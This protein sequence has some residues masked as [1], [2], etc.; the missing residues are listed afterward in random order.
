M[1]LHGPGTPGMRRTR[2]PTGSTGGVPPPWIK[3]GVGMY[4]D[5]LT[6]AMD[7]TYTMDPGAGGT[8]Y[9]NKDSGLQS[10]PE[11]GRRE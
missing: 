7:K 11:P 8:I 1:A 2:Y 9:V 4:D 5:I 6:F 10:R 3:M